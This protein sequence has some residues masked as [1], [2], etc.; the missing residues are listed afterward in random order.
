MEEGQ[1]DQ[2]LAM[3]RPFGGTASL[4]VLRPGGWDIALTDGR[5]VELDEELHFNRYRAATFRDLPL[6]SLPWCSVYEEQCVAYERDCLRAG[7]WG[8]RWAN[9][10]A[11]KMF[12][13]AA[14]PG[15]LSAPSGLHVGSSVPCT[16][17]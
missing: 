6:S 16:T 3:Y 11:V 15:D 17:R 5:L 8:R 10:S 7:R 1:R 4:P 13:P 14:D 9:D 12:G 2:V